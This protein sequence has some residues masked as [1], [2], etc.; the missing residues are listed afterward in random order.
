[1]M[2]IYVLFSFALS[3]L[4]QSSQ[5]K[6][7]VRGGHHHCWLLCVLSETLTACFLCMAWWAPSL[8][9]NWLLCVLMYLGLKEGHVNKN[10]SGGHTVSDAYT[11]AEKLHLGSK[12]GLQ[13][14]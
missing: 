7:P 6:F 1:M 11:V 9:Y 14:F 13:G 8:Y 12:I 4:I 2:W 5:S 10:D 3:V